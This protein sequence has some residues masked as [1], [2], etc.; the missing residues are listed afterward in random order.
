M[1]RRERSTPTSLKSANSKRPKPD[2][3]FAGLA[4][5][6]FANQMIAYHRAD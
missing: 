4:L 6:S 3:E 1:V 5:F 2:V